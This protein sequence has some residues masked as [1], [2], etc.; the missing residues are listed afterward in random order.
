MNKYTIKKN[1]AMQ[2]DEISA[3]EHV[4]QTVMNTHRQQ[5][6]DSQMELALVTNQIDRCLSYRTDNSVKPNSKI[7]I[8]KK[9]MADILRYLYKK[10]LRFSFQLIKQF[11]LFSESDSSLEVSYQ[12]VRDALG[13]AIS[14]L[15]SVMDI[16][17]QKQKVHAF[18]HMKTLLNGDYTFSQNSFLTKEYLIM[19]LHA[20]EVSVEKVFE[21][22]R[23]NALKVFFREIEK[24]A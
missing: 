7:I 21:S 6:T 15:Q 2:F 4:E 17:R 13:D 16:H 11:V 3:I 14:N 23:K 8:R 22:L 10:R 18:I 1:I 5:P 9:T 12:Y 24:Y 19:R 20:L